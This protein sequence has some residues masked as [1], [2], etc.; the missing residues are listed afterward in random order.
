MM[1]Q[2]AAMLAHEIRNPLGII[3]GTADILRSRYSP[4]DQPEPLFQYIPDEVNRLNKL[5]N[6]FL[7]FSRE[8][9]LALA[10][11]DLN[12]LITDTVEKIRL[13]E[14]HDNVRIEFV[15]SALHPFYFDQNGIEQVLMNLIQN[16][17]QAIDT[18]GMVTLRTLIVEKKKKTWIQIEV[19]D[20]GQGIDGD[21]QVVFE[22]FYTTKS[23]GSGLGMAVAKKII[24]KHNGFI[25]II[26]HLGES[27][28][29][30]ILL[31]CRSKEE[32]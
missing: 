26:S 25:D 20:N 17:L 2:M 29:V 13:D 24:E 16:S 10:K 9:P 32:N 1:G 22:P 8:T 27:T 15:P 11:H 21:P 12:Q 4:K 30:T 14:K 6:N 5:V 3:R 19:H 7:T 23:S 28:T 18:T 31:P